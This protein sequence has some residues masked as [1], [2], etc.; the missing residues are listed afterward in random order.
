LSLDITRVRRSTR[1][2]N[3][4]TF[5]CNFIFGPSWT[6]DIPVVIDF[7]PRRRAS[8]VQIIKRARSSLLSHTLAILIAD[9]ALLTFGHL[10]R[11]SEAGREQSRASRNEHSQLVHKGTNRNGSTPKG[12][13]DDDRSNTPDCPSIERFVSI[14]WRE[15][16]WRDC[17]DKIIVIF[18]SFIFLSFFNFVDNVTPE[19]AKCYVLGCGHI[20]RD[21]WFMTVQNLHFLFI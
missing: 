15:C 4:D 20:M 21:S 1:V 16:E 9:I 14:Y 17:K 18:L 11:G 5:R 10:T 13:Y 6:Q 7:R 19:N 12:R 2:D 3:I 8:I